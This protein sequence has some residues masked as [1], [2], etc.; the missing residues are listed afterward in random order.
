[1]TICLSEFPIVRYDFIGLRTFSTLDY[2]GRGEELGEE[3]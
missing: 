2:E 1:M 3:G